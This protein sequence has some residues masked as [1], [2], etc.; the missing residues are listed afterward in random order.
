MADQGGG[1]VGPG[2]GQRTDRERL[3]RDWDHLRRVSITLAAVGIAYFLWQISGI[4]LLNI[5]AVLL[6][7]LMLSFADLIAGQTRLPGRWAFALATTVVAAL[8][9][10]FLIL[11]GSLIRGQ[12]VLVV[13]GLPA[14]V[15]AVG[16]RIGIAGA[17]AQIERAISSG[18]AGSVLSRA[19][20]LGYTIVGA[21]ADLI[22]VV[23]ASIYLAADPKPYREGAA[24]LLPPSQHRR[25]LDAMDVAGNALRLWCLGQ[26]AAMAMVGAVT[27]LA[28]WAIGLPAPLALAVIAAVTNFVPYLGP[29]LG[30]VPPLLFASAMGTEAVLWTIGVVLVV[31]QVEGN[32]ITPFIQSRA[33]SMPPALVLFAIVVFGFLFGA[34][35]VLLAVPLAVATTVLVKKL[36]I[37]QTLGERTSIPGEERA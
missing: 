16:N 21:L 33:V 8:I 11:F 13:E 22:V 4:L 7:V 3:R 9:V 31:Q 37:R 24:K 14:A 1:I 25:I 36:W 20:G 27:G 32:V 12:I 23:V 15:D 30:A 26:L 5:A 18:P 28:Y 34:L 35:G 2:P 6:A 10:G 19:A 29:L 17:S